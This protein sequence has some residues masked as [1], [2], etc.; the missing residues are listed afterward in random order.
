MADDNTNSNDKNVITAPRYVE[1]VKENDELRERLRALEIKL[2]GETS[3]SDNTVVSARSLT[4]SND[5]SNYRILPDVGNAVPKFNGRESGNIAEDWIASVDGLA[6]VNEW[7][8]RYRLQYVRSRVEGAARSWFLYEKFEDWDEFV[9][10]FRAAFV[11]VLQR[12]DQWQ[13]LENRIQNVDEPVVDYFYDKAGMCRSLDLTFSE[14]RDYV[15]EGLRSQ[16][17]AYWTSSRHHKNLTELLS[18]LHNWE[19]LRDKRKTRFAS[20]KNPS[21]GYQR[22][23]PPEKD[24]ASRSTNVLPPAPKWTTSIAAKDDAVKQTPKY[25][26]KAPQCYNCR[27][28]GH[29]ARDCPKPRRPCSN[30]GSTRHT[31]SR[32]TATEE[33]AETTTGKSDACLVESLTTTSSRNPF[34]KTVQ[35]NGKSVDGLVDTGASDVLVRASI[36]RECNISVRLVSRPLYTV[37]DATQPG[38][39][40]TGEGTTDV[41]VDG[42]IEA[43]HP[44]FIVPDKS[45]P[46]DVIV[47]RSWLDLAHVVYFK[48][49]AEL[50][51]DSVGPADP[52]VLFTT[53]H[54]EDLRVYVA[55]VE[56]RESIT[57]EPITA[58]EIKVGPEITEKDR[59]AKDVQMDI[60]ENAGSVPINAKPYRTSPTDRK[61]ITEILQ[62]WKSAGI[63]SDST[64]PY[65]SPV[66]LLNK[67]SGDKRL[68]VDYRKLNQ[69]TV[70]P[71]F[72]MPDIDGQLSTLAEGVIFTTM[73]LSNGFLQIPLSPQAKK[74]TA[75]ITEDAAAKF[76]RM[77]FGVKG[78][79]AMFQRMMNTIFKELKN[80]SLVSV[81]MD[82]IIMP[83]K[84]SEHMLD[85]LEQVF[86]PGKKTEVIATFPRSRNEHEVRRFLGLA[87][88]IRR[89]IV[90]YAKLAAPLTTLTGKNT[91]FTWE[92]EQQKSF[93]ELKRI[94]CSEPVVAMYDPTAPITQVHTDASS[95][96]LSGVLLQGS[97]SSE[98][99][100]VYAVSKKTTDVES[101]YHSSRL[102][103]YAI[104]WT[105]DRLRPFLLGIRFIIF[106][107]CQPLVYLNVH[108]TTKPQVARWFEALQEFDFEIKYRPGSRMAHVDALSRVHDSEQGN[109]SSV[110]TDLSKRLDVF[111]A[112]SPTDRVRFMQQ[113]DEM[114]QFIQGNIV[115]GQQRMKETYD[116]K[117]TVGI[118]FNV[119]EVVVMLRQPAHDQPSKLQGKYRERPL[120]VI[121][122]LPSDTYRVAEIASDGRELYATTAHVSQ[123]KS[124]KILR[125]PGDEDEESDVDDQPERERSTTR[126]AQPEEEQ[127]EVDE[128]PIQGKP[129]EGGSR[130]TRQRRLPKRYEDFELK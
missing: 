27:A 107:D 119:G 13:M 51:F 101:R 26:Y 62:E 97:T 65:A 8:F 122:V 31:R 82:D 12:S 1:L 78:A 11:R 95:V 126:D 36:A 105:L 120:Q 28:E 54:D 3:N 81:Y 71:V 10:K 111:V 41:A 99:H 22:K 87:G 52:S 30:C 6:N 38:A 15:L 76:E 17:Q 127:P 56:Q 115:D 18:D 86:K 109:V 57:W 103:L 112:L 128:S 2:T 92:S 4:R 88:Y 83:S 123:L 40:T 63:V 49:G 91:V 96:A 79:P 55:E 47:G 25:E 85:G 48:C 29:I 113:S 130:P 124:W 44:V 98:L 32:C 59:C 80:D 7:P 116:L 68:C 24:N 129:T 50:V 69:Q 37:G 35:L 84:D 118:K 58:D 45:I 67:A 94:L 108:K 74:K 73:D 43:D 64:S 66:L 100:M 46:V 34:L 121:E 53:P 93:D 77:P 5:V 20:N 21:T 110:E 60:V 42:V 104:I 72:P 9:S 14:T 61:R 117:R 39:E 70:A 90:N 23:M 33:A 114:Q 19:R 16:D 106:T 75:F 102:K 89:F 125:E